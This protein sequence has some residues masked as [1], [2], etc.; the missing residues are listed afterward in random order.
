MSACLMTSHTQSVPTRSVRS[1]ASF[2]LWLLNVAVGAVVGSFWLGA[3]PTDASLGVRLIV[4]IALLSSVATLALVPGMLIAAAHLLCRKWR[5]AGWLQALA[6][7][8]FLCLLYTDT[9]IYRLLGYHFNSAVLNVMATRGSEDAVHLGPKV[10]IV[11]SLMLTLVT[12]IEYTIWRRLVSH[13]AR[14]EAL[15]LEPIVFLRPRVVCALILLPALFVQHT[16]YAAADVTQD[17]EVKVA[18]RPIPIYP[19]VRLAHLLD[20]EGLPPDLEVLP[21]NATLAYPLAWPEIDPDGLRPNMMFLVVDSWRKDMFSPEMT[22]A[23]H[24]YSEGAR[25]WENHISG[26]NGTRFGVFSMLYGLHGSYWWPVLEERRRPVLLETLE[27]LGYD[28]RV[29]SSAS[30]EFPEFKDTAW[31]GMGDRVVDEHPSK[32]SHDR[33][34]MV[35]DRIDEWLAQREAEGNEKPFFCFVLLDSPH[36]PYYN[37][38][39]PYQPAAEE[40]DYIELGRNGDDPELLG[41]VFNRYRNSVLYADAVAGRILDSLEQSGEMDETVLLVTGDHGEEFNECG[42]WGH[43][44]SFSRPQLDVPFFMRGPGI[45]P[46]VESGRTSHLDIA[47]TLLELIGAD[48]AQ[49][50][51]YSLGEDLFDPPKDRARVVAGWSDLGLETDSGTICIPLEPGAKEVEVYDEKWNLYTDPDVR[52]QAESASLERMARECLRFLRPQS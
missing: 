7:A 17:H 4:P 29:F 30:M 51:D 5:M 35:A 42:F 18:C 50:L 47:S 39:G 34:S 6:G 10:W 49:R 24:G 19:R 9:I 36:Q 33:D 46:G 11:A 21:E 15:G 14:R 1:H 31:V 37:N 8:I 25:V 32:F 3:G 45:E 28:L 13:C 44:S 52:C 22:P 27:S 12:T 48:P 20:L 41:L 16:V 38:G 40:V 26:G 23:I 2:L 43:T